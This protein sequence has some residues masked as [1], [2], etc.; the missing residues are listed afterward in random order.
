M[1]KNLKRNWLVVSKLREGI[2]RILTCALESLKNLHLNGLLLT[3]VYNVC[4]KKVQ[5]SYLSWHW[6]VIQNLKK[7]WLVS[8][9]LTWGIW[10]I[11]T[12][13]LKISKI[14]TLRGCFWPKYIMFQLKKDIGVMFDGNQDLC[15]I[16]RK[17]EL[18]FQKWHEEFGKKRAISFYKVKWRN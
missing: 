17:I 6:R 9:K 3:K 1:M 18:R 8:S 12:W 7:S 10:R 5:R 16:W 11:F 15:K 13:A 14:W 2:W 4:T